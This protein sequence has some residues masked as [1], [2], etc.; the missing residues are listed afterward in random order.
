MID[1]AD[2]G[3]SLS[4]QC[5]LLGLP[6]SS[7]YHRLKPESAENLALMKAIDK[8]HTDYPFFGARQMVLFLADDG[9]VVNRKRVR[10]LMVLMRLEAMCPKPNLSKPNKAHII[11]PYLLRDLE[12]LHSNH[13]WSIDITYV[14][15]VGG[16]AYL[17]AVID[18][19][20]RMVLAWSLSNTIDIGFCIETLQT[21]LRRHGTPE[22][23]NS[24]QGSQ[25]TSPEFTQILL[26]R[27]VRI[28]MDGRGRALDNVFIERL[29][30]SVKYEEIYIFGYDSLVIGRTRLAAY[31]KFYN[32]RRPH[33]QLDGQKPAEA[34]AADFPLAANQ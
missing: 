20:S 13:V 27:K 4:H 33:S 22:I 34:Y 23:F 3:L 25:F 6:R 10:R 5:R 26:D 8:A 9:W 2:E 16:Y 31:F 7:Y 18:W 12:I 30:R 28:S 14:P 15:I 29:W 24:D 17:C 21:A 19:H 1:V 11:Y 32:Y